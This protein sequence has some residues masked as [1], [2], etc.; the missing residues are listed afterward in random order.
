MRL[1]GA[2][3]PRLPHCCGGVELDELLGDGEREDRLQ[4]RHYLS[5]CRDAGS[6]ALEL[7][8]EPSEPSRRQLAHA[9]V[10]E[11]RDD[12]VRECSP[13]EVAGGRRQVRAARVSASR[14]SRTPGAG[15]PAGWLRVRAACDGDGRTRSPR[16]PS[17]D[18]TTG[19]GAARLRASGVASCRSASCVDPPT[20]PSTALSSSAKLPG[21]RGRRCRRERVLRTVDRSERFPFGS[22]RV[23]RLLA[24]DWRIPIVRT[25]RF[26][27][28]DGRGRQTLA[29]RRAGSSSGRCGTETNSVRDL[30]RGEEIAIA[31]RGWTTLRRHS[32]LLFS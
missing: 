7:L 9:V 19:S 27:S 25:R 32:A 14:S 6:T 2:F 21:S 18:Q 12:V 5:H 28:S 10:A 23:P 15:R 8:A 17:Y 16:R 26:R 30:A 11:P 3:I 1:T 13:V 22:D 31:E 29:G 24:P 20:S 4:D